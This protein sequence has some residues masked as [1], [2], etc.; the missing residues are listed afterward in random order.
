[1]LLKLK[2][3]IFEFLFF[4]DKIKVTKNLKSIL[5]MYEI[6]KENIFLFLDFKSL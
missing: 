6:I 4:N 5:L 2:R 1:M 3:K